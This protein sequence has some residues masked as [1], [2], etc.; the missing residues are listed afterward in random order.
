M[1]DNSMEM[2]SNECKIAV[3]IKK[4]LLSGEGKEFK[5]N[6]DIHFTLC[7]NDKEYSCFGIIEDIADYYFRIGKVEIDEMRLI[8]KLNIDFKEIK[9]GIIHHTDNGWC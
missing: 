5:I 3:V 8:D 7:R 1:G 2:D 9:N 6:D 4:K